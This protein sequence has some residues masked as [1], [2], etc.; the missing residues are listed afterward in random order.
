MDFNTSYVTDASAELKGR[1]FENGDMEFLIARSGNRTYSDMMAQQ[2][3]AHQHTL[4]QKDTPEQ[5]EIAN[6][7]AEKITVDI[8]SKTILLGWRG[9]P[10][11]DDAGNETGEVGVL[12][13]DGAPLEYSVANAAKLLAAKDFR[14]W[15]SG[16]AD[17][18]KNFLAKAKEEDEKNSVTSSTG[19]S[20][21][22]AVS[23]S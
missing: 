11:L 8:M 3:Q 12:N 21:G 14:S 4:S 15:V 5:R 22:E 10:K 20:N 19:N 1:W 23:T 2:F 6:A 17:D 13:Y 7:R 16:R 9:L 18:F